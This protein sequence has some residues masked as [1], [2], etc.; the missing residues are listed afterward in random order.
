MKPKIYESVYYFQNHWQ[1]SLV[2]QTCNPSYLGGGG[3]EDHYLKPAYARLCVQIQYHPPQKKPHHWHC[4]LFLT[5]L[6]HM[7]GVPN[8]TDKRQSGPVHLHLNRQWRTLVHFW[9]IGTYSS[10]E[11]SEEALHPGLPEEKLAFPWQ[12]PNPSWAV[13]GCTL[14]LILASKSTWAPS[15]NQKKVQTHVCLTLMCDELW[16]LGP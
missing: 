14:S 3:W 15:R 6:S 16:L 7:C 2:A 12:M 1:L 8:G 11:G 5:W 9:N 10:W 13:W 4:A